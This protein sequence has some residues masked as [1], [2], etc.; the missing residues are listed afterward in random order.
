[1]GAQPF[2]F[3]LDSLV[4]ED[5]AAQ[6]AAVEGYIPPPLSRNPCSVPEPLVSPGP[7]TSPHLR[8]YTL[9]PHVSIEFISILI[10]GSV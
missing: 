5:R 7:H 6:G 9:D 3:D 1:M 10:M 2:V 8:P 4:A